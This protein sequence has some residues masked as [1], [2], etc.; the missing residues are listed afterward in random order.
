MESRKGIQN[1]ICVNRGRQFI[2]VYA[3]PQGYSEAMKRECLKR[4]LQGTA[5]DSKAGLEKV[6]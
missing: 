6:T 2:D 5:S 1:H 3:P 4:Y